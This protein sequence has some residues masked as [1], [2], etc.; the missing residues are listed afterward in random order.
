MGLPD[1]GR[2]AVLIDTDRA[3]AGDTAITRRNSLQLALPDPGSAMATGGA[4]L[5][6]PESLGRR[7]PAWPL[8]GGAVLLPEDFVEHHRELNYAVIWHRSQRIRWRRTGTA[9]QSSA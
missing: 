7:P 5:F 9:T 3:T 2:V 8:V 6:S 1:V 4:C